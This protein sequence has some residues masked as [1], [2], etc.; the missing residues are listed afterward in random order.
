MLVTH[1][2]DREKEAIR[3]AISAPARMHTQ[4]GAEKESREGEPPG[5]IDKYTRA[6]EVDQYAPYVRSRAILQ[7]YHF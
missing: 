5:N 3:K 4:N 6:F 2:A 7:G 1:I